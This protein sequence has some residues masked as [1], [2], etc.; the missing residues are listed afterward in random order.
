MACTVLAQYPA[1]QTVAVLKGCL[2][3]RVW[4]VRNN[5][6]ASLCSLEVSLGEDLGDVLDGTDAY[7]REMLLYHW[8]RAASAGGGGR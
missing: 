3:S 7:A 2:S 6:A 4:Y 5:A 1:P 8:E